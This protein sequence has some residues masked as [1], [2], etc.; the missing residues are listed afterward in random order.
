[1]CGHGGRAAAEAETAEDMQQIRE[2]EIP[3]R[4]ADERHR[5]GC[6]RFFPSASCAYG[7]VSGFAGVS[8]RK[9]KKSGAGN[10][11]PVQLYKNES[12]AESLRLSYDCVTAGGH[13]PVGAILPFMHKYEHTVIAVF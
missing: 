2:K 9:V 10:V 6:R 8:R 1:M 11:G 13:L 7:G 5:F 4:S 3:W 12:A